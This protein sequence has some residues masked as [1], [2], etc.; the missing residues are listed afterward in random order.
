MH[1][2]KICC[3]YKDALKRKCKILIYPTVS[4]VVFNCNL[5]VIGNWYRVSLNLLFILISMTLLGGLEGDTKY[6]EG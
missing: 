1:S 5:Y 2:I 4:F 6:K 3:Y